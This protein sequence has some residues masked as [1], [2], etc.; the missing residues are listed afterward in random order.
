MNIEKIL[1]VGSGARE[2]AVCRSIIRSDKPKEL[3]CIGSNNNPGIISLCSNFQIANI[4]NPKVIMD[5]A[6]E[7]RCTLAIIGPENPLGEGVA[8]IL[9]DL[10][11]GVVGPQK[12]LAQIETSKSFA[13][14]LLNEF[15]I[16]G[17]PKYET[18]KSMSGV[19]GFLDQLGDDFVVKYDGLAGGKGV[20]VSGEH[21]LSTNDA[22]AYCQELVGAGGHFVIEEKFIG[23]E[24]SLMSFC[25]GNELKHMPAVQDHKRAYEGDTGPNTGG[26]GTYSDADHSLPFLNTDDIEQAKNINRR[27]AEA[28]KSKYGEGYKGI[29]YGGFMATSNGVKLIEYNARLGDPEAMNVL[30]LLET[31]MIDICKAIESETLDEL[32]VKFKNKATV[33]KYAVPE[34]YPDD[35]IKGEAIDVSSVSDPDSLFFASVDVDNERLIEAGSRTVAVVGIADSISDAE[36]I[37]EEEISRVKGPLFHRK[38]IGTTKLVKQRVDHMGALR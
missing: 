8:D 19:E 28:L 31:D 12:K 32:S 1:I 29:L 6:K 7:M 24:F 16:P 20:K 21:L 13:R 34:G 36:K 11:I 35:P 10:G 17:S 2:H 3:F 37:A 23:E 33:C 4:N 15:E 25:D 18:F 14:D 22:L 38:D 9:G 27:T 5:F 26:M 30:S